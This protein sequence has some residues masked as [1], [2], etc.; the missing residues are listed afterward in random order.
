MC[1]IMFEI[2]LTISH[3]TSQLHGWIGHLEGWQWQCKKRRKTSR[4]YRLQFVSFFVNSWKTLQNLQCL[5]IQIIQVCI[6]YWKNA[7]YVNT[8][9]QL[10]KNLFLTG[11]HIKIIHPIWIWFNPSQAACQI[12]SSLMAICWTP[13]NDL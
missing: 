10:D 4:H 7:K 9:S 13:C 6:D 1:Q 12:Y 8:G 5:F 3:S 11:N 2:F